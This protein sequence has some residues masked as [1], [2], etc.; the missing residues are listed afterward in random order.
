MSK[1]KLQPKNIL[2]APLNWGLGHA[3]R[4]IPIIKALQAAKVRVFIASDGRALN[5]LSQEFPNLP[6]LEL[7][8]YHITYDSSN[9]VWNIAKQLHKIGRAVV[10]EHLT[11]RRI[12]KQYSIHAIISD[13][14]FG[15]FHPKVATVFLTHQ[16]HLKIPFRPLE[17]LAQAVNKV[18]IRLFDEC[19]IPDEANAPNLS[20]TLSHPS[21]IKYSRYIGIL[22]RMRKQEQPLKYDAI[23]VLSGPEPQR[24]YFE[25]R[26]LEQAARLPYRILVVGGK[27]E[28]TKYT[29]NENT[30]HITYRPFLN[31][32][33]LNQAIAASACVI[34]RSGYSTIMDLA[35]LQKKAILVPTPGQTEQEYLAQ[36][37]QEQGIFYAVNQTNFDLETAMHAVKY[38]TAWQ[39]SHPSEVALQ[40][41][42]Q[43]LLTRI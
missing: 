10:Q 38:Y 27:P 36:H 34:S 30:Q 19:W 13:N 9:M 26:I 6:C 7:P 40:A 15:C 35:Y 14:R 1:Q 33:A 24:S 39:Q 41:A 23:A 25:Q 20:G 11:I 32:S 28:V 31:S 5:L 4:C 43:Q 18:C 22:S 17:L 21:Q 16:I 37:F 42:L 8:A 3:T 29:S 12:V 2:I